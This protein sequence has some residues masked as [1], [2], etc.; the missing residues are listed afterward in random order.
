MNDL[1]LD[2][3]TPSDDDPPRICPV[4]GSYCDEPDCDAYGCARE[5]GI[6]DDLG[7]L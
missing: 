7:Y 6:S 2:V 3:E 5:A 1:N 4:T